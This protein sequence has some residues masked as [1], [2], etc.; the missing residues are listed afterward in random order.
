MIKLS[1]SF[2][3]DINTTSKWSLEAVDDKRRKKEAEEISLKSGIHKAKTPEKEST[4]LSGKIWRLVFGSSQLSAIGKRLENE[5]Y[6]R[7]QKLQKALLPGD[8]PKSREKIMPL[9]M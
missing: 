4:M 7:S 5:F 8:N 3:R 9:R 6:H 1:Y 2:Y